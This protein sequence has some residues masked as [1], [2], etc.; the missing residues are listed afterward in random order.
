MQSYILKTRNIEN[1][2]DSSKFYLLVIFKKD[3]RF[4]TSFQ[5]VG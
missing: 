5:I 3:N 4:W 2:I 1:L